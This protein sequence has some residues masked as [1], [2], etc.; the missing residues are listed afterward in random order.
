MNRDD[1]LEKIRAMHRK[2]IWLNERRHDTKPINFEAL[3]WHECPH[4]GKEWRSDSSSCHNQRPCPECVAERKN[5]KGT[6]MTH[7]ER[8]ARR[9]RIAKYLSAWR[10]VQEVS[11]AIGIEP[12]AAR[13]TLERMLRSRMVLRRYGPRNYRGKRKVQYRVRAGAK[14]GVPHGGRGKIEG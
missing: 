14:I 3:H 11:D 4:C 10:T 8:L 6:G 7:D 12:S 1:R 2:H 9:I 5:N 13:D